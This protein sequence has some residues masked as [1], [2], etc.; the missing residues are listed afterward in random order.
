MGELEEPIDEGL[1]E[2]G[3]EENGFFYMMLLKVVCD[4]NYYWGTLEE[5][6]N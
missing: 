1:A 5:V 4:L 6:L 2:V 3:D